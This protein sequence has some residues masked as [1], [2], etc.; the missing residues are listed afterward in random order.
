MAADYALA[1][2][3]IARS[4]GLIQAGLVQMTRAGVEVSAMFSI[5]ERSA[6]ISGQF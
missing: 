3:L 1:K 4:N 5:P 2:D 6:E